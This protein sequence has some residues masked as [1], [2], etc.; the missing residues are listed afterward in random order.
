LWPAICT[1]ANTWWHRT[2]TFLERYSAL[3]VAPISLIFFRLIWYCYVRCMVVQWC[4][5]CPL[6]EM[7]YH[8]WCRLSP[9][10]VKNFR[11]FCSQYVYFL[12]LSL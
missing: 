1:C 2:C 10:A 9:R 7:N 11:F 3:C 5:W 12:T 4:W 8:V 6:I